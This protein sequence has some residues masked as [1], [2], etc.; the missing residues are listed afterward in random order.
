VL[1]EAQ[2]KQIKSVF[3]PPVPVPGN[4]VPAVPG[5]PAQPGK[6]FSLA[7]QDTLKLSPEQKKRL[8]EIQQEI[9]AKLATLL[10]EDQKRQLQAMRQVPPGVVV[11]GPGRPGPAGGTPLFR[12][13]RYATGFP[14]FAGKD[15]TP[16][17]TLEGPEKKEGEQKN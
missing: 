16:G 13:Y 11:A 12:A 2:R 9:D 6:I 5:G 4:P 8:E 1:T 14:G 7:Q 10:T 15:L 17:K 3:S